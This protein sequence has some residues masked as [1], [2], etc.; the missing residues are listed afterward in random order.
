MST[1]LGGGKRRNAKR[2]SIL[3]GARTVFGRDGYSRASVDLIASE[4]GVSTRTI[5]NHFGDKQQLFNALIVE[6]A[7]EVREEQIAQIE[8]HIGKIEDLERDLRALGLAFA[9]TRAQYSDHF[10]LVRQIHAEAVH[11]PSAIFANWQSAGPSAVHVALTR[12]LKSLADRGFL[13]ISDP[14]RAARQFVALVS[15]EVTDRSLGGALPINPAIIEEVVE[16]GV[17]TFL[18]AFG[19]QG[20]SST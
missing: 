16:A 8:R 19:R 12:A 1:E 6:S 9:S 5:Y 10:A 11:L 15:A 17:T 18:R 7:A 2:Q 13:S 3:D 4:A 14:S 20:F